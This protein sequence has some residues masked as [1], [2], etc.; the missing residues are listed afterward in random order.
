MK[1]FI[2]WYE[3]IQTGGRA[4]Y[5]CKGSLLKTTLKNTINSFYD[6]AS[7]V[8]NGVFTDM[9]TNIPFGILC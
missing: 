2:L 4:V 9:K 7:Q 1:R 8:K 5:H 6:C 3:I